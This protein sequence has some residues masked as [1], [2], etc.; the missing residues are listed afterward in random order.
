MNSFHVFVCMCVYISTHMYKYSY[1]REIISNS[2]N[3]TSL[4]NTQL[5][6]HEEHVD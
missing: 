1:R 6:Y 2:Q 3:S 5:Q 4:L